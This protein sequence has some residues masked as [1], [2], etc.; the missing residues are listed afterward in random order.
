MKRE[1]I[2]QKCEPEITKIYGKPR[3]DE[4]TIR[5]EGRSLN[6]YRCDYCGEIIEALTMCFAFSAW[7]IHHGIPYFPWEHTMLAVRRDE[8]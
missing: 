5:K 4:R 6:Q 3:N 7:S 8:T 2:C 1:I